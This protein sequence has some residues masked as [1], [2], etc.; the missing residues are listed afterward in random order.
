MSSTIQTPSEWKQAPHLIILDDG[1]VSSLELLELAIEEYYL[2]EEIEGNMKIHL[3]LKLNL[4]EFLILSSELN[5]S[6][7]LSE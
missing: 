3:K 2:G 4:N 6:F 1:D 7:F 5:P